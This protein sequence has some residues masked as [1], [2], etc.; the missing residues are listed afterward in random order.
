[1]KRLQTA[2]ALTIVALAG[3][4]RPAP[5]PDAFPE[6]LGAWHRV[7]P[8]RDVPPAQP[9]D[10]LP[11]ARIEQIRAANYEGPGALEARIY[12]LPSSAVALDVVQRWTPRPDTVMFSSDRFFVV[13]HWQKADKKEL[14]AFVR[15]LEKRL[16]RG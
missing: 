8:P 13:V 14:Q 9:P 2:L 10:A 5:M 3:C 6:T 1:M 15:E 4:A 11:P 7:A 12:V 16:S